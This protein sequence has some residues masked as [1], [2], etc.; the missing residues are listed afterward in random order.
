MQE[1]LVSFEGVAKR[2]G[3][4]T[5]VQKMDLQIHKGEFLA[6]MGSSGCGKTTT[7][8]MLAGL[9]A[10]S[11]GIIRLA[12][13]PIN[14]LPSWSRDTP[15]VWQSL[16]LFPFLNVIEN[17]EFALKM[18]GIGR[19]ERRRRAEQWLDRMQIAE[20]ASRNIGQLSGGQRQRVALARSLV[21][22][23]D[24]LLLDEPLS[25][26]DAALKVRMQSVLKNLQ[27]ETGITFVYV[28]HSQ[29]EA[30]SMADRVVIMSR[31]K[32]EQIGTPQ[33]IYRTPRT[34][35]V[36]DFL[37]SSNIFPGQ[38]QQDRSGR[39]AIATASGHFLL[40]ED[41]AASAMPGQSA[42][43]TVLD[44]RMQIHLQPPADAVNMVEARMIGEE[45]VGATATIYFETGAGQEIRVQ[46]SHEEL[47]DLPLAV[48]RSFHLSWLP[49]DGHLVPE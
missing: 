11:E 18:R 34:R 32:I 26:L 27:R 23:P 15:M 25:A 29:S 33:E 20:F 44:T 30:F 41:A 28:T 4:Y 42:S 7:L 49:A 9:E 19:A 1:P 5:A 6:I 21:V 35:F 48:G 22:E 38:L 16:A 47:A 24:I 45:F 14:D 17:V 2:F 10:P 40:A 3:S 12:G 13:R 39:A 8:R 31:G 37:G 46:K 43:L 36:A